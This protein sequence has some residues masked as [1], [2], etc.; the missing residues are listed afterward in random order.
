MSREDSRV[1]S[2]LYRLASSQKPIEDIMEWIEAHRT[3]YS[4]TQMSRTLKSAGMEDLADFIIGETDASIGDTIRSRSSA[5]IGKIIGIHADGCTVDVRWDTGG[6][7]P[8]PKEN[9]VKLG[10]KENTA[11]FKHY[12]TQPGNNVDPYESMRK[13]KVFVREDT[14]LHA[15]D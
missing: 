7:Q 10:N 11:D 9:L 5:R 12:T 15:N 1:I 13:P 4:L 3:K 8:V 14:T 6:I 2:S